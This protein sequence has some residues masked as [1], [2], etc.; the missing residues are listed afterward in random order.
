MRM[1]P[2]HA[3]E[4]GVS[5]GKS[6]SPRPVDEPGRPRASA[7]VG[8][9]L[10]VLL[11]TLGVA[12]CFHGNG[13]E[14]TS[15]LDDVRDRGTLRCGV[16]DAVPGFG[17]V[18]AGGDF[19]G[20]DIDYC[21][22]VAAGVLGDSD[23][24][25]FMPLTAEQRFTAL[26]AREIDVLIRNTTWTSSRDGSEGATFLTTSFYDG[27]GMMVRADSQF[28]ELEDMA[29]TTICVLSGTTTELNLEA[30]FRAREVQYTPLSFEENDTLQQ[31]FIQ[32]RC[33]GW[34]SDKSQLA[35]VRSN[36]P[37]NQ[38]GPDALRILDETMSKEPLGPVVRDG[39]SRWADAVNWIV[40]ATIQAEEFGVTSENVEEMRNSDDPEV[41][42]F[43]GQ[44]VEGEAFDP[45][46]GL[47]PDFAVNV[48]SAVG[49]YGEIYER[50]VGTNTALGL[51]RG[52]NALWTQG[53]LL[54]APPYR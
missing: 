25:E 17:F 42:R 7:R 3:G 33:D 20:F 52:M 36:W 54:Y 49:N 4:E 30:Q 19:Q 13:G 24:V 12:G 27:Q 8:L 15:V 53:G 48:V 47:E 10:L 31:A 46:L 21:R 18:T 40:I 22:A 5:V 1:R 43:L 29:G 45:G 16:N 28:Q 32:R 34:T 37:E 51:E 11:A 35:G 23:A 38:G 44:P 41:R 50:N 14:E 26:Q 6:A 9:F 2:T 39:D